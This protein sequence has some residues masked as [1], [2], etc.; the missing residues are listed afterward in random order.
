M[1]KGLEAIWKQHKKTLIFVV[2]GVL[3]LLL[4]LFIWALWPYAAPE[5]TGFGPYEIDGVHHREKKLW[6]WFELLIVPVVLT[7]GAE[8]GI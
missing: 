1:R 4:L 3:L 8:Q 7:V 2:L 6:D 5:W